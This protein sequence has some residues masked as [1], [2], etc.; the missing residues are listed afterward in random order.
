MCCKGI[1]T[2][3]GIYDCYSHSRDR[4]IAIRCPCGRAMA[5][6]SNDNHLQ[7][8]CFHQLVNYLGFITMEFEH[9]LED[10]QFLFVQLEQ[11]RNPQTAL[12]YGEI[13]VRMSKIDVEH[14]QCSGF[15]GG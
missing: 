2:A 3:D 9:C 14:A 8:E 13:V 7:F 4:R 10:Y 15:G 11:I 6:A 5:A 12:Y 1:A